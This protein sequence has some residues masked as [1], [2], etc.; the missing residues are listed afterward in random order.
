MKTYSYY[1]EKQGSFNSVTFLEPPNLT[2]Y[3]KKYQQCL[4]KGS[5]DIGSTEGQIDLV[6]QTVDPIASEPFSRHKLYMQSHWKSGKQKHKFLKNIECT[7]STDLSK[8]N[9]LYLVIVGTSD[10]ANTGFHLIREHLTCNNSVQ[11]FSGNG[12]QRRKQRN[13]NFAKNII[14]FLLNNFIWTNRKEEQNCT[15]F[16]L[17]EIKL[18]E[19]TIIFFLR[20]LFRCLIIL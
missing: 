5:D 11:F 2:K 17:V 10:I 15:S 18:F 1:E 20:F 13:M 6:S 9:N 3:C 19:K 16:L 4:E 14:V 7:R 8:E 12:F